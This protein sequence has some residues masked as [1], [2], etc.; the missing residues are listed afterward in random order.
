M[1]RFAVVTDIHYGL[2]KA[3]KK[4][5]QAPRLIDRFVRVANK[6]KADFAVDIGDRVT[7]TNAADDRKHMTSLKDH[8]NKLAM[9][10][11]AVLGNH[12]LYRMSRADN[13]QILGVPS[14]SHT[15]TANGYTL[16][17]WNPVMRIPGTRGFTATADDLLWLKDTLAA[18]PGKCIVFSHI[19]LDNTPEDDRRTHMRDGKPH[20]SFFPQ[21]QDIRKIMEDSGKVILCMSGHRHRNRHQNLNGIHYITQQSLVQRHPTK[22]KP[23]GAFS[24]VDI[25]G[26][27]IK[28]RGFGLGQPNYALKIA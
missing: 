6:R 18:A 15:H 12:D 11:Y 8:F 1:V 24:I 3:N 17:F 14:V 20:A 5:L 21:G 25:D 4:G 10:K 9:P 27:D 7:T 26:T 2:D 16:V 19:P 28:I 23:R 13:E 22:Y